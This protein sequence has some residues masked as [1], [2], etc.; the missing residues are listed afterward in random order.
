MI[1]VLGIQTTD[2]KKL[3]QL[4]P[5]FFLTGIAYIAGIIASQSLFVSRFGVEYLPVMYL[6]EALILPLQLWLISY[7]SQKMPQGILIKRMYLIIVFGMLFCT[8]LS[9]S[10]FLTGF[11]WNG[12]YPLLFILCSVL[13]RILV[14]LM[15][16]L[17]DG[18]CTLQQ[19]K[20]LFPVLGALFTV[21]ATLAGILAK[22]FS[23]NFKGIGTELSILL[24]LIVLI[25]SYF[26]WHK[27]ISSY[28]LSTDLKV[29]DK[30]AT[31]MNKVST[32]VWATP[33]LRVALLSGIIIMG[34]YYIVD[35]EFFMFATMKYTSSDALTQFYGVFVAALY[36]VSLVVG[37]FL[38]R[39]FNKLGI[40]N[41]V[42]LMGI[43]AIIVLLASGI[44]SQMIWAL[45][46]FI[47]A[48]IIIDVFSFSLLPMINQVLYKLLPEEQRAGASLLFAGSIN[49]GGKLIS[50]VITGLHS[51][52]TVTLIVLSI[53]GFCIAMV[54]FIFTWKQKR[55]YFSTLLDSL[56]SH[57]VR[58]P[59]LEV[60]SFGKSLGK[61]DLL[62]IRA[63][64]QSGDPTKELIAL[65]LCVH[66]K[67]EALFP[68]IE[69]F[70]TH[71]DSRK[72]LL[73]LQ[74]I[75]DDMDELEEACLLALQNQETEIRCEA[76]RRIGSKA[77]RDQN[78]GTFLQGR[79]LLEVL[80][81]Y[82]DDS[83]P[84]VIKET[85]I[86]LYPDSNSNLDLKNKI[87]SCLKAMLKGDNESRYQICQAIQDLQITQYAPQVREMLL[88]EESYRVRIAAV[89]CLG[90]LRSVESMPFLLELFPK[91]DQELRHGIESTF[92]EM[93]ECATDNLIQGLDVSD[94]ASWHLR[95]ITLA[96]LE[97]S[98]RLESIL[99]QTCD[100]K[101]KSFHSVNQI[102]EFLEQ[103]EFKDLA[104]LY[105]QRLTETFNSMMQACWKTLTIYIDP[106]VVGRLEETFK[107]SG[108][109][110]KRE[111]ALEILTELSRKFP[112]TA[113]IV[114]VFSDNPLLGRPQQ[115]GFVESLNRSKIEFP[116]PWLD[117]FADHAISQY[118]KA[119]D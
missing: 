87:H 67:H 79:I 44:M 107:K 43:I 58:V 33:L 92:L 94:L 1:S 35:Y 119:G 54:F 49:A 46:A 111:Q 102:P 99:N 71:P 116:D 36:F 81:K 65:E 5:I 69:P 23:V 9:F 42:F 80:E 70:L 106:L 13:L 86:A 97:Q 108:P 63:A 30:R 104:V 19:A 45:Q 76:V 27:I 73:A 105:R 2:T 103:E 3:T 51:S 112:L 4:G 32:T 93:G 48:D 24:V 91:A 7:L 89:K 26:L 39:I 74:S 100:L 37:L 15:W 56:Q 88:L 34:L 20:R 61:G 72:R 21:G 84:L 18:I 115:I 95:V 110:E 52:G 82:L 62:S 59:E 6:L 8:V 78:N 85:I 31:P 117:R 12:V 29:D 47:I 22:L 83:S 68:M 98:S 11:T 17:G 53:L 10:Q 109:T 114:G 113:E 57:A 28:F 14:P 60:F 101:L 90:K 55:L 77:G 118:R 66:I 25:L 96:A 40:S 50:S 16:M 41:T 64:L 75:Q 38:N